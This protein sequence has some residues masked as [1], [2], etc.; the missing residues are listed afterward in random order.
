M[1]TEALTA[2]VEWALAQSEVW[3]IGDVCDVDNLAS[4]RVMEKAG[5]TREALLRRWSMH[6]NVSSEPRDCF[7]YARSR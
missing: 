5:L 3:R 1:M 6:P 7:S 4:A 2:A